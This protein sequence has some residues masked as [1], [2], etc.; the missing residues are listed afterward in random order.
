MIGLRIAGVVVAVFGMIV[1]WIFVGQIAT[2]SDDSLDVTV[3]TLDA[4]DDTIDLG[5]T[6]TLVDQYRASVD[7]ARRLALATN[8]DL[9]KG[10]AS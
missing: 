7:D 3:Q 4:V 1:G 5:D 2:A 9:D 10:V 6:G 8:N